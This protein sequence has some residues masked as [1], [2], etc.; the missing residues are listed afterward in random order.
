M[1]FKSALQR[2]RAQFTTNDEFLLLRDDSINEMVRR[3]NVP[4]DPGIYIIFGPD[5]LER[6]LYIGKA[7]TMRADGSCKA[8]GIRKR[9]TMKQ[10]GK[11]R[12]KYFCELMARE[13][14]TGLRFLWFVTLD[15]NSK[16]IPALAEMQ[17]LQA[18][19]NDTKSLPKLN[20]CA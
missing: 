18:Y 3:K 15:Q 1:T 17:L 6:P 14:L 7:G 2:A 12:R 16:I 19:Y 4:D 10:E 13:G 9:L 20:R 5:D 8:Q 11:I